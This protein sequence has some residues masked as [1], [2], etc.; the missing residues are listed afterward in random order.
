M[1]ESV[2]DMPHEKANNWLGKVKRYFQNKNLIYTIE[3]DKY[4]DA[5]DDLRTNLLKAMSS[6]G[7]TLDVYVTV[8]VWN[9]DVK[10]VMNRNDFGALEVRYYE[11]L[12]S[13]NRWHTIAE[14]ERTFAY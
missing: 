10:R 11:E 7:L 8:K 9:A 1:G 13:S 2:D 5:S 4:D 14:F 3:V 12:D 6:T